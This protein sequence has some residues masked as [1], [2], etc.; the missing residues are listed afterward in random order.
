[1]QSQAAVAVLGELRSLALCDEQRLAAAKDRLARAEEEVAAARTAFDSANAR[2]EVSQRVAL[3]A[4][5]LLAGVVQPGDDVPEPLGEPTGSAPRG[6]RPTLGQ[7]MV[8]YVRAQG[9]GVPRAEIARHV[10]VVRPDL[11]LGGIG[12]ELTELVR[13]G[14]LIRLERGVYGIPQ[15]PEAGDA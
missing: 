3:G 1:M 12:P 11:S 9:R 15:E 10:S 6:S 7:E 14:T 5:E 13:A 2:A 4:E 8:A